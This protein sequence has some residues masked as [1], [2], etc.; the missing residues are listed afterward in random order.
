MEASQLNSGYGYG[1]GWFVGRYR[2]L[3]DISQAAPFPAS[4]A[5]C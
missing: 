2:G 3:R 5:C 4:A 1:F